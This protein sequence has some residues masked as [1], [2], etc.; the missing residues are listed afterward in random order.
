M[1]VILTETKDLLVTETG[2]Y[3]VTEPSS[4]RAKILLAVIAALNGITVANG[5]NTE[6]AYVSTNLDVKNVND[7]DQDKLPACFPIDDIEEKQAFSIGDDYNIEST[8]KVSVRSIVFDRSGDTFDQRTDLIEDVEKAI[9]NSTTLFND[10][11]TGL[12]LEDPTPVMIETDKGYFGEYS[13]FDQVF[14]CLYVYHH[15]TME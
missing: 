7:I 2:D 13:I 9:V 4:I 6:I 14:D 11:G 15:S 1:G 3:I 8:L 10:S 5:Y 12:L